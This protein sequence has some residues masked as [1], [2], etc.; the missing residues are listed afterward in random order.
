MGK[1]GLVWGAQV[2]AQKVLCIHPRILIEVIFVNANQTGTI[3]HPS[4]MEWNGRNIADDKKSLTVW[5]GF[6]T[7]LANAILLKK[8]E[9]LL[10][11]GFLQ[12]FLII[13]QDW[14]LKNQ[15]IDVKLRKSE[16]Y[17]VFTGLKDLFLGDTMKCIVK[18]AVLLDLVYRMKFLDARSRE[19]VYDTVSS[20]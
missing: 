17:V 20:G 11:P 2:P 15:A 16:R 4:L 5:D 10:I 7:H 3:V 9:H 19:N 13:R 12:I 14:A 1:E 6:H 8:V 18:Y